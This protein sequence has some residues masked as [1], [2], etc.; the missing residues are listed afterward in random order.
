[1]NI[2]WQESLNF[3]QQFSVAGPKSRVLT[4]LHIAQSVPSGFRYRDQSEDITCDVPFLAR[5]A[6]KSNLVPSVPGNTTNPISSENVLIIQW[7]PE[8]ERPRQRK[9][10]CVWCSPRSLGCKSH[11][12]S[13]NVCVYCYKIPQVGFIPLSKELSFFMSFPTCILIHKKI[14]CRIFEWKFRQCKNPICFKYFCFIFKLKYFIKT[15]RMCCT[16][17]VTLHK[18][19]KLMNIFCLSALAN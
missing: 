17:E 18:I 12:K 5:A 6:Q 9:V 11:G 13:V 19:L 15:I 10:L 3:C 14:F 7:G 4:L 8:F 1:M 2:K 16:W